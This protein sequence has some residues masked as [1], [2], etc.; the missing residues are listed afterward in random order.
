[1][2]PH[3]DFPSSLPG[4]AGSLTPGVW[5]L[6]SLGVQVKQAQK[7]T[8]EKEARDILAQ[9]FQGRQTVFP[10]G[11][12]TS[13]SAGVLPQSIDLALDTTGMDKVLA[14]DPLNLNLEVSAGMTLDQINEFLAGQGKGFF[15]PL[16][17]PWS[18]RATI[19]GTYAANSSGP[20]RLRYGTLRDLVLGVRGIDSRGR[21]IGFGGKTVKNV[22]G[23]DFT[24]FLIGSAGSL[25][26]VTSVVIRVYPL[27]DASSLCDLV[28]ETREELEKF[29]AALRS[30]VLLPSAVVVTD[31]AG[32]PGVSDTAGI[33]FR[34]MIGFEGH[35]LAVERQNKDLL[36]LAGEFGGLGD[37]RTGRDTMIQGIR[38]AVDPVRSWGDPLFLRISVP[39]VQG[40]RIF[41]ALRRLLHDHGLLGKMALCAP[42]GVMFLYAEGVQ[43]KEAEDL[44]RDLR[45]LIPAG[46]GYVTPILAQRSLLQGWGARVEP[47]LHQLA[48]QPIKERLDPTGVFPPIL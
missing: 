19:G 6:Q 27:P 26:L 37:A 21:E 3:M 11:G 16:D 9:A 39:I 17:P 8:G 13:L 15:L 1:L 40:P 43:E 32:G 14:F 29:L 18:N 38:S 31:L 28:F 7:P 23:Y 10:C 35:G 45:D 30:S 25:C 33:R 22:S 5:G 24:K 20:M 41:V 42:N 4:D 36:K 2:T 34:V 48:F 47:S 46:S 44:M 12:G